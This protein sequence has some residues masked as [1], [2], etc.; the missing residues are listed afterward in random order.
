MKYAISE[1]IKTVV[2]EDGIDWS[3]VE[4]LKVNF[5]SC[6]IRCK[7]VHRKQRSRNEKYNNQIQAQVDDLG[8]VS[9][10]DKTK[11]IEQHSEETIDIN[12]TPFSGPISQ[13]MKDLANSAEGDNEDFSDEFED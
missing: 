2:N 1:G 4:T 13:I 11:I 5:G 8:P 10:D 7:I 12:G 3:D 9:S 6:L